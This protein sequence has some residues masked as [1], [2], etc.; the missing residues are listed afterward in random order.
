MNYL[1]YTE[2]KRIKEGSSSSG[3]YGHAGRPGQ[4]GGSLP[5]KSPFQ[6]FSAFDVPAKTITN[7]N[8]NDIPAKNNPDIAKKELFDMEHPLSMNITKERGPFFRPISPLAMKNPPKDVIN[9]KKIPIRNLSEE[10]AKTRLLKFQ[11][12]N[13]EL[14]YLTTWSENERI[15]LSFNSEDS[16][17]AYSFENYADAQKWLDETGGFRYADDGD[18]ESVY[19]EKFEKTLK[20]SGVNITPNADV[21]EEYNKFLVSKGKPALPV[22]NPQ[23][24]T[25]KPIEVPPLSNIVW[26]EQ[27]VAEGL[28]DEE[29]YK[30]RR[31]QF[32]NEIYGKK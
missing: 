26:V 5:Y 19:G 17:R 11:M 22:N 3:D 27:V 16:A 30:Q 18:Y 13:T 28:S 32:L 29:S 25:I 14:Y 24:K 10:E 31:Q 1:S 15:V 7:V 9:L 6:T 4:V 21:F 20:K 23:S 2:Y 8:E 12:S